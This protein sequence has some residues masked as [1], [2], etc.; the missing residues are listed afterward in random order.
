MPSQSVCGGLQQF[1]KVSDFGMGWKHVLNHDHIPRE[2]SVAF[3]RVYRN[4]IPQ[5]AEVSCKLFSRVLIRED[6]REIYV[7]AS[8]QV[9]SLCFHAPQR[10]SIGIVGINHRVTPF[11]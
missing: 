10:I 3:V 5:R 1:L 9:I 4:L 2:I 6:N 11:R 8:T 7:S